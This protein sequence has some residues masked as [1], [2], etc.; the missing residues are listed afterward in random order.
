[1]RAMRTLES[2]MKLRYRYM[3]VTREGMWTS[4]E[5]FEGEYRQAVQGVIAGHLMGQPRAAVEE[6]TGAV[7]YS[8]DA[9][10]EGTAA[11]V[12]LFSPSAVAAKAGAGG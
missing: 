10:G 6:G 12:K 9:K 1:M 11:S 4:D 8:L 3:Q 2:A 5:V 7:I